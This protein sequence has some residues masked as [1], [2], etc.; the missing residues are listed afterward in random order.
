MGEPAGAQREA[1]AE[2]NCD[3]LAARSRRVGR[4]GLGRQT[5]V[6]RECIAHFLSDPAH[7]ERHAL[8]FDQPVVEPGRAR[9]RHLAIEVDIRPVGENKGRPGSSGPPN[10]RT[11]T[12]PPAGGASAKASIPRKRTW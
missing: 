5:G 11:S 3:H 6:G 10:R 8:A 1:P 9:R 12:M 7:G 4:R 2:G